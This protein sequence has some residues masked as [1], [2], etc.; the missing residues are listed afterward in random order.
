MSEIEKSLDQMIATDPL[1]SVV[2]DVLL[3]G[4]SAPSPIMMQDVEAEAQLIVAAVRRQLARPADPAHISEADETRLIERHD[5]A[6]D[7]LSQAYRIVTGDL[8]EWSNMFGYWDAL[9][10]IEEVC[11][12]R[13][14]D[15][16]PPQT[17]EEQVDKLW[18]VYI[19]GGEGM[20]GMAALRD[21]AARMFPAASGEVDLV[22]MQIALRR[23]VN[24]WNS[25]PED[26]DVA[27]AMTG[28][29]YL[30]A[31]GFTLPPT[32]SAPGSQGVAREHVAGTACAAAESLAPTL[33]AL[34][35]T[36]R[37][38]ASFAR[39]SAD[40]KT[41]KEASARMFLAAL[42][43]AEMLKGDGG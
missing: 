26:A 17:R 18:G 24:A 3:R 13:S 16:T 34:G 12:A 32:D 11:T 8:P 15:P 20:L 29:K 33:L 37:A 38:C 28:A 14:A 30:A 39:S 2:L 4:N 7:A 23:A 43:M 27:F 42:R 21:E 1:T 36:L 25:E 5:A 9:G 35:A 10:E 41:M 6:E 19:S 40:D 22:A 31:A